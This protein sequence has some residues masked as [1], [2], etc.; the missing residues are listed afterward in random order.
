ML[1]RAL[2]ILAVVLVLSG[3]L[4]YSQWARQPDR[5]SG[6]LEADDIRVGSR[7]GGRVSKVHV[8]EGQRVE[9][10]APLFELEPYDLQERLAQAAAELAARTADY[11]RLAKGFRDEEKQQA[12]ARVDQLTAQL[13]KLK[14]G[15][16][17]QEIE[18]AEAQLRLAAAQLELAQVQFKRLAQLRE[19]NAIT[20]DE[21]DEGVTRL[22]VAEENRQV[23][24]QE[25]AELREGTR[26]EDI[27]AAEAQLEEARQA[28][29]LVTNGYRAEEVAEAQAAQAAAQANVEAIRQQLQELV[30]VA[31]I[32]GLVES[33]D[34]EPG[35][36]VGPGAPVASLIDLSHLWVRAYIPE[37]RLNVSVGQPVTITVD[38]F[39]GERFRGHISFIA[40]QAEFT[41]GNVQ[42]PEERSKQV[43]RV[44][45]AL[46]EA[47]DRL[48]P[49][50]IADVWLD[51][52]SEPNIANPKPKM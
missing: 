40:R 28:W 17:P 19:E 48:R 11:E 2:A 26:A 32:A 9:P 5:V 52:P 31:P 35:D 43:F 14:N 34:L 42:T 45:A 10:G 16:R 29:L 20:P 44:K 7:V 49:G 1:S 4:L 41:P 15:P 8:Q 23:R 47:L 46:D 38:S 25:L 36:L 51:A 3:M 27:A 39:P 22:K 30:V 12:K 18:A 37:N 24:E 13:E 50:M 21:F 33:I 6:F